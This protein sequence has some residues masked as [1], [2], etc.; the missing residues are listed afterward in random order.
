MV[1]AATCVQQMKRREA[2]TDELRTTALLLAIDGTACFG[3]T[4]LLMG[5]ASCDLYHKRQHF[6]TPSTTRTIIL[7]ILLFL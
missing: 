5:A 6:L 3:D 4:Y 1:C 2:R 7:F